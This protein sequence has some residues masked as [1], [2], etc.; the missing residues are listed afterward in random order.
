LIFNESRLGG[1]RLARSDGCVKL[2]LE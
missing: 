2:G 1:S